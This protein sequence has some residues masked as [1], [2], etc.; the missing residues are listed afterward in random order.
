MRLQRMQ[1][2]GTLGNPT[3]ESSRLGFCPCIQDKKGSM[4][5]DWEPKSEPKRQFKSSKK[6]LFKKIL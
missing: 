1:I 4:L 5:D 3:L 2:L 6:P